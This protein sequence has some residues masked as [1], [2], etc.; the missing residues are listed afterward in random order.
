MTEIIDNELFFIEEAQAKLKTD[1][2]VVVGIP[3]FNEELTIARVV[4]LSQ[5]FA[6]AVIVCDDGSSDLTG[7]IAR[8]MGAEVIQHKHNRGY[9]AAIQSL[10]RRAVELNADILVTLD[11]DGQHDPREIPDVV[12]PIVQNETDIVI[13]SRFQNAKGTSEMRLYRQIGA[14]IVTGIINSSS[15]TKVTDAQSG[16]RAYGINALNKLHI[17]DNG[18]GASVQIL[19]D[20][21]RHC[22]N[23]SEVPASCKY[24]V[25]VR[26]STINPLTHGAG[27]I[28]SMI[29]FLLT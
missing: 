7:A 14:K 25:G 4:L 6:D 28:L 9:G 2:F 26:T 15:K 27:L 29:H 5:N 16:F 22:L 8:R 18:M 1:P 21:G 3:A 19:L 12:K 11:G 10:F 23:I 20:A 17:H 24:K 13:G